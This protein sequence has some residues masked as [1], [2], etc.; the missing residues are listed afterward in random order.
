M[1]RFPLVLLVLVATISWEQA[2]LLLVLRAIS[3]MLLF[4]PL[5][6]VLARL[7]QTPRHA[8]LVFQPFYCLGPTVSQ[9]AQ[10]GWQ[11]SM[12]LPV[13]TVLLLASPANLRI[14][15]PA[16]LVAL[17]PICKRIL[18]YRPVQTVATPTTR[19]TYVNHV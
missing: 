10:L 9:I 14:A 11:S 5:V 1:G 13:S 19:Q 8:F 12:E 17:P 15:Q 18:V 3:P 2:A 16:L 7:V 4:A 6:L